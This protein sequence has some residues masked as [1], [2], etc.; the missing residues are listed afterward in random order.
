MR[1][2]DRHP[3]FFDRLALVSPVRVQPDCS[4]P[5][6][7]EIFVLGDTASL[8][9]DGHP[10]PGVAQ[11][12]IQQGRYAGRLIERRISGWPIPAR[13]SYFDK[14]NMA[15]VGGGFAVL[16]TGKIRMNGL[17][18]WLA[19]GLVHLQF[20]AQSSERVSVFL[21]WIWTVNTGQRGSRLIVNHYGTQEI[22][23]KAEPIPHEART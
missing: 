13:F 15:A 4:V 11:V 12:A 16:Q 2:S 7:P 3:P 22:P 8:D 19:W 1:L 14:G 6:S 18:A 20:L 9:E 17:L 23:A 21:Q 5:G 10:L